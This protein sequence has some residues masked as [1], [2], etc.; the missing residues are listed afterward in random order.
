MPRPPSKTV[1]LTCR[2]TP[3]VK[4]L[5]ATAAETERR[6]LANMLEVMVYEA[7]QRRALAAGPPKMGIR[8]RSKPAA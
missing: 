3:E 6:S 1:M 7:C 2:V 8:K 4:S 5:L